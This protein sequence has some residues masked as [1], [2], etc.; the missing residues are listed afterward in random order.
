MSP[1]NN[2]NRRDQDGQRTRELQFIEQRHRYVTDVRTRDVTNDGR[3]CGIDAATHTLPTRAT[4]AD[5]TRSCRFSMTRKVNATRDRPTDTVAR[6]ILPL[7]TRPRSARVDP[8]ARATSRR[9]RY[10]SRRISAPLLPPRPTPLS[11][12]FSRRLPSDKTPRVIYILYLR[13]R[14]CITIGKGMIM[15]SDHNINYGDCLISRPF[16]IHDASHRVHL[17]HTRCNI[18]S[19]RD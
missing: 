8:V 19:D 6:A 9:C 12:F 7:T 11:V 3:C 14:G 13:L 5:A 10:S 1:P 2:S 16:D 4:D 15:Y 18:A 17:C